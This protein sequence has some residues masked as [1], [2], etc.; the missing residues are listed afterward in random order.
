MLVKYLLPTLAAVGSVAAQSG[1][2][3]TTATIN[4][5]AEATQLAS[6]RSIKGSV[7]IAPGAGPD[8]DIS[9][10]SEITGD[11]TIINNGGIGSLTANDLTKIG[12]TFLARNVT[13]LGTLAFPKLGSV[14]S[15]NW[16]SLNNLD[17]LKIA[18]TQAVNVTISDTFLRS[19]DGIDL[20]S[21]AS[22]DINN[23]K[24]LTSFVSSLAN[25][26]NT[27]TINA[28]GLE[29]AV[30]LDKLI[31]IANMQ[32]SNVTSFSVS[33]LKVVNSSARF[34]SNYFETFSA[35]NLTQTT[36]NDISF[37]GNAKLK[38][39]TL[40]RLTSIGGA[41][42]I[43]NNTALGKVNGFPQLANINGAVKMR[44]NFTTVEFPSLD[45]V[46]GAF[47]ISSTANI[48]DTCKNFEKQAPTTQGGNNDIQGKY[49]CT[50][51]NADAN[52]DTS[53]TTGGSG[54]G[55]NSG[56]GNGNGSDTNKNSA[57]RLTGTTAALVLAA[58]V[59]FQA[60]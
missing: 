54:S 25:L 2:C 15:L 3:T 43:A 21:V 30:A 16:Q 22:L 45:V 29:L 20:T 6:C 59:A 41:L 14:Q 46:K 32:I 1:V 48:D 8:I 57:A 60:L 40:P 33:A 7:V 31:W 17:T 58:L 51:D 49:S 44:G 5:Q 36:T 23:N 55:S 39:I 35:P 34:D 12:G 42:L 56:S 28:N 11:L 19:L 26:S 52:S 47:D 10:P 18:L 50:S 24:R 4:S 38:N 37:V 27:L 53:S 9:G 13:K